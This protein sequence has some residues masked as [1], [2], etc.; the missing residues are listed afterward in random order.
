MASLKTIGAITLFVEELER[1]KAFY[2]GVLGLPSIFE[3]ANSA[4]FK[5]DNTIINLLLSGAAHELIAP[6][7]VAGPDAGA[8]FQLT[9]DVDDTDAACAGLT[10]RG[11]TLLNGPMDR[12]WGVRTAAFA[13]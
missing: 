1:S 6:A 9:S 10:A 12:P 5:F 11:L 3:D 2:G 13:D 7:A 4:V 8:R